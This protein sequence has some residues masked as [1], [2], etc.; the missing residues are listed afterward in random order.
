LDHAQSH[1]ITENDTEYVRFQAIEG[2]AYLIQGLAYFEIE[3]TLMDNE[4]NFIA[5]D[6]DNDLNILN[7]GNEVETVIAWE[8]D[9][10][11]TYYVKAIGESSSRAGYYQMKIDKCN[12]DDLEYGGERQVYG[13]KVFEFGSKFMKKF[14]TK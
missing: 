9:A 1:A 6:Q 13:K 14:Q 2:Q 11:G 3:I 5:S 8:C 7:L 10:S 4:G 12:I